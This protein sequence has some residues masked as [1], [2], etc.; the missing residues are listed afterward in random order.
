VHETH[1]DR[2]TLRALTAQTGPIHIVDRAQTAGSSV[3][4]LP[5]ASA[6]DSRAML[7]LSILRIESIDVN[8]TNS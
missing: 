3:H 7:S 4:D 5:R 2:Q 8:W 6:P 1:A